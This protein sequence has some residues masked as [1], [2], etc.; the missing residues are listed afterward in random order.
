[1]RSSP[2]RDRAS[3]VACDE[4]Q[5]LAIFFV[6]WIVVR[7]ERS[8]ESIEYGNQIR[9]QALDPAPPLFV[10]VALNPLPVIFKVRLPA[11]ERLKEIF[12]FCAELGD[13]YGEADSSPGAGPPAEDHPPQ[14]GRR[15]GAGSPV[16]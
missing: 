10:A 14:E 12:L 15:T 8:I 1:M 6:G 2:W 9:D 11:D 7:L 13:L 3:R 4:H 5:A 16:S